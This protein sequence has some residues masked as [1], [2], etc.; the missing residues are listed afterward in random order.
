MLPPLSVSVVSPALIAILPP[1]PELPDPTVNV[2]DPALPFVASPVV[3]EYKPES[4]C[5]DVCVST[6]I[7]PLTPATPAFAVENVIDPEDVAMPYPVARE[8]D[9]PLPLDASPPA[10]VEESP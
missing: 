2:I 4:P 1:C 6:T 8:M 5:D 9:P 7:S 3:S 10:K